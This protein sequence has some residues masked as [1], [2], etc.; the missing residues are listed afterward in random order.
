MVVGPPVYSGIPTRTRAEGG[1]LCAC[2]CVY[3]Y[4]A[5]VRISG[6]H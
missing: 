6:Q 1:V 3:V 5:S 4:V 2:V